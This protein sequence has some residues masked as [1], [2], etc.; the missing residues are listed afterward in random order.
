VAIGCPI[1][2]IAGDEDVLIPPFAADA[3]AAVVPGAM[4]IAE[5][6]HSAYFERAQVFNRH[7]SEFSRPRGLRR[8]LGRCRAKSS[9]VCYW[10]GAEA[11]CFLRAF[12]S[13]PISVVAGGGAW[14]R[15]VTGFQRPR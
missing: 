3:I 12:A 15:C 10:C 13:G 1:L 9:D 7:V 8:K 6:G 5:A 14:R 4:H 11:L 2:F